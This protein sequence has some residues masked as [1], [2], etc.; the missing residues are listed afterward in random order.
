MRSTASR[1]ARAGRQRTGSHPWSGAPST[2]HPDRS[3]EPASRRPQ[4]ARGTSGTSPGYASV[5]G[6]RRA[7]RRRAST[8]LRGPVSVH[9]GVAQ[10]L[11]PQPSKLVMG[12][13]FPSPAPRPRRPGPRRARHAPTD[14]PRRPAALRPRRTPTRP[15]TPGRGKPDGQEHERRRVVCPAARTSSPSQPRLAR[16]RH[17]RPRSPA[18]DHSR[19]RTPTA[20]TQEPASSHPSRPLRSCK[21]AALN[22]P[23]RSPSYHGIPWAA[24][25]YADRYARYYDASVA[26][27]PR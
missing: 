27:E 8:L 21:A 11:E 22:R 7:S 19:T 9:A 1:A 17:R 16:H 13:R 23:G 25:V 2:K 6:P 15:A 3:T 14:H 20:G 5:P 4:G 24:K 10:W 18:S 26:S 12:V